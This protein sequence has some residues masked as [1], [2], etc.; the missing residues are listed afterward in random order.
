M[1]YK[2]IITGASGMVGEGV[3]IECLEHP[4]ITEVLSVGRRPCGM[5]H[6]K[7]KEYIV[8]DFLNLEIEGYINSENKKPVVKIV[9]S[10]GKNDYDRYE[11]GIEGRFIE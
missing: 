3:L 4:Q 9:H 10:A 6:S 11:N 7:L 5:V 1:N 8:P 2:V